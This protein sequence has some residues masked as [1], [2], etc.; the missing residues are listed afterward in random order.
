MISHE[1][2]TVCSIGSSKG[3]VIIKSVVAI[4]HLVRFDIYTL[5]VEYV[6]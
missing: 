2:E 3:H 6:N 5:E 1:I 4:I